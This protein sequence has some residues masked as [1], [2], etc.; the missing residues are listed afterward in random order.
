MAEIDVIRANSQ[1]IDLL[2]GRP[3]NITKTRAENLLVEVKDTKQSIDIMKLKTLNNCP[4]Y[5]SSH[6]T[7]NDTKGTIYYP[8]RP[9]YPKEQF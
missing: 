7:L 2:N 6:I 4:V 9:K 5:V 1:L 8:N 3:K